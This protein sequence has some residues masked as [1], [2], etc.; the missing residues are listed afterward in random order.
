M[1]RICYYFFH[2][3]KYN[4]ERFK[5]KSGLN[6]FFVCS[7]TS[8]KSDEY[9]FIESENVSFYLQQKSFSFSMFRKVC[10]SSLMNAQ[11]RL[12]CVCYSREAFSGTVSD[13]L[14]TISVGT[15]HFVSSTCSQKHFWFSYTSVEYSFACSHIPI[16]L[17]LFF[18]EYVLQFLHDFVFLWLF[19]CACFVI[20]SVI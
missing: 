16:P 11:S 7:L 3:N 10:I 2:F 1:E 14:T 18:V 19:T 4:K 5:E 15:Y 12:K 9:V 13:F 8:S 20:V 17:S 6:T